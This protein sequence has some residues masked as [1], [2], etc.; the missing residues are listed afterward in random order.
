MTNEM[1]ELPPREIQAALST[2][3]E[4]VDQKIL[5]NRGLANTLESIAQTLFRSWFVDF[6]PVRAK[7]AGEKPAGMDDATAALFPDSM[8]ESELGQIPAGWTS[9]SLGD[10]IEIHDSKRI[11]LS[12]AQRK[13]RKGIYPYYGAT[14]VLDYVD[15][16]LF[17]GPHVLVG[18]DG[19]VITDR[20]TPVIQYVWGDFWV[21]NHAHVLT[22]KGHISTQYLKLFLQTVDV[23]NYI[24]GAVQQ[25]LNQGNLRS[26]PAVV[27]QPPLTEIFDRFVS[28]IFLE[29]QSLD[30][31]SHSLVAIRDALLSRLI[32]GELEVPEDLLVS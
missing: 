25:K 26:I 14:G 30:E 4:L 13:A 27:P 6:D 20:G 3:L 18:E 24:T 22:G 1:L 7:M 12:S 28:S 8:E 19:T 10:L 2:P 17:S 9:G 15:S 23:S 21:N 11:P 16:A 29:L 32:S 5:S 31:E